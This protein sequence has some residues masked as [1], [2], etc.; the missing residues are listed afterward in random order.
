[1][2]CKIS[3]FTL[4]LSQFFHFPSRPKVTREKKEDKKPSWGG[5]APVPKKVASRIDTGYG[6][7]L[8]LKLLDATRKAI[9][10]KSK[11]TKQFVSSGMQTDNIKTKLCKDQLIDNQEDLIKPTDQETE[12]DVDLVSMKM[13]DGIGE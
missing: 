8:K 2:D 9:I 11:S 4:I 12:T 3:T 13:R 7:V 10:D 5:T 1:M 6:N